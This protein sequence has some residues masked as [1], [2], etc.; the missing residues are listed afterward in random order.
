MRANT[1]I[2]W[3]FENRGQKED[4]V[5]GSGNFIELA[6]SLVGWMAGVTMN[7]KIVI[8]VTRQPVTDTVPD[9]DD[10][11]MDMLMKAA[12]LNGSED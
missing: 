7:N 2:H 11:L 10:E 4:N 8:E 1:E 3:R 12:G 5:A 6:K 9:S